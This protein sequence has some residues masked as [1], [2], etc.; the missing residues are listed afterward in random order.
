MNR[1]QFLW[2]L[3]LTGLGAAMGLGP[4][5]PACSSAIDQCTSDVGR[6]PVWMHGSIKTGCARLPNTMPGNPEFELPI[7]I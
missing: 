2:T 6:K 7:A 3:G 5:Q 4:A 1:R